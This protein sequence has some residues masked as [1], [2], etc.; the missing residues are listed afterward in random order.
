M[1]TAADI[2]DIL[3]DHADEGYSVNAENEVPTTGYMVGG[4][5]PSLVL[6]P[7]ALRPYATTDAWLTKNW[8]YFTVNPRVYYAG[9]WTDSD[10][11]RIYIDISRNVDTF[12]EA[13]ALGDLHNEIAIWDVKNGREIRLQD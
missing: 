13:I 5:V 11:G 8:S 12:G 1:L 7:D 6:A 3:L 2:T 4:F 9:V 10:T